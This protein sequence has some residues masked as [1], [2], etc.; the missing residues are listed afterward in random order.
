[1]TQ[2]PLRVLGI[3]K[4]PARHDFLVPPVQEAVD[5]YADELATEY[6]RRVLEGIPQI[7]LDLAPRSSF[8]RHL[9]SLSEKNALQQQR[10]NAATG[11]TST[12]RHHMSSQTDGITERDEEERV[13][14][15]SL[16]TVLDLHDR[17]MR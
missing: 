6:V 1:M 10:K 14:A 11:P 12:L 5:D 2:N 3:S 8:S 16:C 7:D 13:A 15:H 9:R 17:L 4:F